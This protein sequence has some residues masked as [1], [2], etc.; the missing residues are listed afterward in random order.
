MASVTPG[1]HLVQKEEG[2]AGQKFQAAVDAAFSSFSE[3]IHNNSIADDTILVKMV[4]AL[5]NSHPFKQLTAD[6]LAKYE[7]PDRSVNALGTFIAYFVGIGYSLYA[8][9][10]AT[11]VLTRII[12]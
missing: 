3:Q 11:E 9:E 7:V 5:K 2:V 6:L 12:G 8:A 10:A 1:L 4:D